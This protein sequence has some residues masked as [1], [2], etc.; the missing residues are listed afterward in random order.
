[1]LDELRKAINK[2]KPNK[3]PGT[4]FAVTVETFKFGGNE[5]HNAVLDIF[6][7]VLIFVESS[8]CQLLQSLYHDVIKSY[9]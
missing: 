4:D 5:L 7:S 8:S 3:S 6:N 1:M 2:M 9:L